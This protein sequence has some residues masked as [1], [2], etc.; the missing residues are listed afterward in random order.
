MKL[1]SETFKEEQDT[2]KKQLLDILELQ[3]ADFNPEVKTTTLFELD[4]DQKKAKVIAL[5][6]QI[7]KYFAVKNKAFFYPEDIKRLHMTIIRDVLKADYKIH[8]TFVWEG[9]I[10]T[11]RYHFYPIVATTK[12]ETT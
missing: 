9:G 6:P 3:S 5:I 8:S 4:Q 2:I 7:R 10:K 1:K 12:I 11:R